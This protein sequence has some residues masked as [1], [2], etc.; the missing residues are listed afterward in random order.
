MEVRNVYEDQHD[1]DDV[2]EVEVDGVVRDVHC[3]IEYKADD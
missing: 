1:V 2:V 3:E